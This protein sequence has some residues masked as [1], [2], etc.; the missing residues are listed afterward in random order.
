MAYNLGLRRAAERRPTRM[1]LCLFGRS[2]A[3]ILQPLASY[4]L[5]DRA[6]DEGFTDDVFIRHSRF[7]EEPASGF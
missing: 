5:F 7:S 1:C 3:S 2:G 4:H 6:N